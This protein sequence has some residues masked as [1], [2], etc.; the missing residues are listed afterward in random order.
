MHDHEQKSFM[1]P[2]MFDEI[3]FSLHKNYWTIND[4]SLNKISWVNKR[5][6]KL[7]KNFKILFARQAAWRAQTKEG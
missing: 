5:M 2:S 1:L 7:G 4:V 3:L 6:M